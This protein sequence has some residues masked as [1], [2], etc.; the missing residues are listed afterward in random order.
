MKKTKELPD[1]ICNIQMISQ[2]KIKKTVW[3]SLIDFIKGK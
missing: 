3:Q 1:S 2:K